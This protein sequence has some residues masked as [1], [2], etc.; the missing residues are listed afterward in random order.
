MSEQPDVPQIAAESYQITEADLLTEQEEPTPE[1]VAAVDEGRTQAPS[2]DT[3]AAAML[4][5]A[6]AM[7]KSQQRQDAVRQI[8]FNEL[9][10]DTPFNPKGERNRKGFT[11][12]TFLHGIALN[13]LTHTQAEMDLFN[14]LKPG[15][16]LDRKVEVQRSNDGS[17]NVK[18]EGKNRD[19]RIEFYTKYPTITLL[20]EAIIKDREAKEQKRKLGLT[21]E[22][23]EF[24]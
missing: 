23:D 4:R 9:V 24:R 16:Y 15:R 10:P 2:L 7:E 5:I 14:K 17:I 20:L 8:P 12:P 11:R 21:Y 19:L 18:W 13:P 6:E 22:E 3:Y 1:G